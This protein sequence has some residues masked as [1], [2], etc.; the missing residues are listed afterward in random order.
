MNCT[1][2]LQLSQKISASGIMRVFFVPFS[3]FLGGTM[4]IFRTI[5]NYDKMENPASG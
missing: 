2:K 5:V 4:H 3:S 1:T